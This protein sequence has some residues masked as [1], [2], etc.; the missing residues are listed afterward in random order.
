MKYETTIELHGGDAEIIVE[1]DYYKGTPGRTYGPP[2][3]CFPPEPSWVEIESVTYG[4]VTITD[5]LPESTILRLQEEI[6]EY[7]VAEQDFAEGYAEY[8]REQS[9]EAA[10][11][12]DARNIEYWEARES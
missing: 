11:E 10:K 9:D 8:K 1:Y 12:L 4:E 3:K 7:I 5:S 2:E 6:E